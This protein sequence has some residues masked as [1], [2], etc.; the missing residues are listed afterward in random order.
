M[1]GFMNGDGSMMWGMGWGGLLI[2]VL[3][4]LGAAA[5]GKYLFFGS[6]R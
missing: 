4:V 6:R 5:L 2:P 3:L 1:N